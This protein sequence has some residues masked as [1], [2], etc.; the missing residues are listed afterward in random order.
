VKVRN[1]AARR[2]LARRS[3]SRDY[4]LIWRIFFGSRIELKSVKIRDL[5]EK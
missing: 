3:D 2:I 5:I 4:G 1:P